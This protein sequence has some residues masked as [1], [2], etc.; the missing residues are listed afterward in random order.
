MSFHLIIHLPYKPNSFRRYC[1]RNQKW[2]GP[3]FT[4]SVLWFLSFSQKCLNSKPNMNIRYTSAVTWESVES[5]S[6]QI[7][8][9]LVIEL[10][11]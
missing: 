1:P 11:I 5:K 7:R 6:T 3:R 8:H 10:L 9:R 4:R 2:S